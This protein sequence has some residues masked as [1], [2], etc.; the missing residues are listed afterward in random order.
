MVSSLRSRLM[1]ASAALAVSALMLA[2]CTAVPAEQQSAA[3]PPEVAVAPAAAELSPATGSISGGD[4]VT[5]TGSSLGDVTRVVIGGVDAANVVAK[6]DTVTAVVPRAAEYQPVAA[7]VEVFA[8]DIAVPASAP[9]TF[10]YAAVTPVD[11]Q[12]QYAFAHW[13]NYNL[14][15][16]GT[17]NPVGGDC[18]N[19]VSQ[20][21]MARGWAET[22]DWYN[23]NGGEDWT[24]SWIHVPTFDNWLR[25]NAERLGVTELSLEQRDQ[26]KVGDVVMFDWNVNGALDHTQIVS[27]VAVV[28]GVTKIKMVGHNRDSN[29][30]D[31]DDT[32]TVDHPGGT[33]Y[34]WSI[35]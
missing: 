24:Y 8:G 26:V 9:L 10:S 32:L 11:S 1:S 20:T 35:P 2:G 25:D 27:E 19:F 13:N 7:S 31:L 12:L 5:I 28:D 34:F 21:L 30:R 14:D 15:E 18:V 16:Y 4:T 6:A 33:A 29:W 22:D 3:S 23:N 17:F